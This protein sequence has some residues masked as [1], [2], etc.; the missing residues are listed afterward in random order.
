MF[1]Q[2]NIRTKWCLLLVSGSDN[3]S[4]I[5]DDVDLRFPETE[6]AAV[7]NN[8]IDEGKETVAAGKATFFTLICW[9]QYEA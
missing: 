4:R 6:N 2:K 1:G 5:R 7:M 3:F 9:R 8:E